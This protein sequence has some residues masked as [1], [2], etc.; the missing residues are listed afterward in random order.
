MI[1]ITT[2]SFIVTPEIKIYTT[3]ELKIK[4]P[5]PRTPSK[6]NAGKRP[7]KPQKPYTVKDPE[8]VYGA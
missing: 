6:K 1:F 3:S 7:K 5:A 2:L 4:T 8:T